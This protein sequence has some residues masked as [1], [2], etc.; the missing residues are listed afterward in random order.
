MEIP[1]GTEVRVIYMEMEEDDFV[2]L[3][4]PF[5]FDGSKSRKTDDGMVLIPRPFP[6]QFFEVHSSLINK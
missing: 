4:Q 3:D 2:V 1:K 5:F 6:Q